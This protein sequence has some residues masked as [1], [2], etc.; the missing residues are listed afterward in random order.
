MRTFT[1]TD[2]KSN[3]FWSIDLQGCRCTIRFGKVGAQGQTQLKDF[4]D[5]VA[6]RKA[7]D[8]LVA[9]KLAKGYRETTA[10]AAPAPPPVKE[11]LRHPDLTALLEACRQESDDPAR[12]QVLADWLEEHGESARAE[13]TRLEIALK[14]SRKHGDEWNKLAGRRQELVA[15]HQR[16][17]L[18]PTLADAFAEEGLSVLS[19]ETRSRH[20]RG[21]ALEFCGGWL[22]ALGFDQGRPGQVIPA[23]AAAPE[24]CWL[25]QFRISDLEGEEPDLSPLASAQHLG[26]LTELAICCG[27]EGCWV[28]G[29]DD[30]LA[31]SAFPNLRQLELLGQYIWFD[32]LGLARSPHFPRLQSLT[33]W[34]I[35]EA[36]REGGERG[37]G[38]PGVCRLSSLSPVARADPPRGAPPAIHLR[39]AAGPGAFASAAPVG[40]HRR[41]LSMGR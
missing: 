25:T 39:W 6:A 26:R 12:R 14:A 29:V 41:Q 3:K 8:K 32:P 22:W 37:R 31:S 34:L 5:E 35:R 2:G 40:G 30:L 16:E 11:V 17:W 4:P 24:A 19:E 7:H 1:F 20:G 33:M 15:A 18:G 21:P 28:D 10:P 38:S 23:L 9:E 36:P 13:I 27:W